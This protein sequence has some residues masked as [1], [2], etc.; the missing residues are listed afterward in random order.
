MNLLVLLWAIAANYFAYKKGFYGF[1]LPKEPS[2][3]GIPSVPTTHLLLC[4]SIYLAMNFLITPFIAHM[5]LRTW[6]EIDPTIH[7]LPIQWLTAMQLASMLII[8][9]LLRWLLSSRD[10]S[11]YKRI[12]KDRYSRS[13]ASDL[14]V[15]ALTWLLAFPIVAL[16]GD[17]IDQLVKLLLEYEGLEQVAVR[18]VKLAIA[19]P[20]ALICALISVLLLAPLIEELLFRGVLQTYLKKRMGSKPA[21]LLSAFAFALFHFSPSQRLSNVALLCSLLVLGGY[22]GLLYEKRRS[23]W[24]PIGLHITFNTI[25]ALRILLVPGS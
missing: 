18:F 5:I 7:S 9:A 4:F 12:W 6:N 25:S 10:Q 22:L 14:V 1:A 8:F 20:F 23:L 11:L 15:G 21:I 17:W 24:A 13:A 3:V 16:L 2:S 19:S